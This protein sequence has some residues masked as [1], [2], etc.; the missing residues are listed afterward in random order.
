MSTLDELK[1]RAQ[2]TLA[3]F[4]TGQKIGIA[5]VAVLTFGALIWV[6]TS[7]SSPNYRTLYADLDESTAAKIVEELEAQQIPFELNGP[8]A[9]AV[10]QEQLYRAR[11]HLAGLGLPS[12]DGKGYELF[13]DAEFGMT[14]FTQKVNYQRALEHELARTISAMR[15][16]KSARVHLVLPER[17]LF[18][19]EQ[20][21][22]SASVALTLEP[23]QVPDNGQIQSMRYLVSS[24]I[25]SLEPGH[26]TIVDST[27]E[28]LA[29]PDRDG[30]VASAD[31]SLEAASKLEASL[32][33]RIVELLAPVVGRDNLRARVRAE[34]DTSTST[35]TDERYDPEKRAVRSEQ[36][37]ER[38]EAVDGEVVGGAPGIASNLPGREG[39]QTQQDE[40]LSKSQ[41]QETINYEVSRTVTQ[42]TRNGYSVDRLSVAVVLNEALL[43]APKDGEEPR[44]IDRER[45]A[46]LI[47]S[48]VGFQKE[49]G[50]QV[51]ITWER[52]IESPAPA[53]EPV[54]VYA[55]PE[56]YVPVAKYAFL[57]LL[58]LALLL[59]VVRP[60][61]K[62]VT[63]TEAAAFAETDEERES[64]G[65]SDDI[66][67]VG[68]TVAQVEE[69]LGVIDGE[70]EVTED[71]DRD[72]PY[73]Q[74]REEV[75]EL[76]SS[77]LDKTGDI[78]R[79]WIRMNDEDVVEVT[80]ES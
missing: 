29:R 42:T 43:A 79:Q 4:T 7:A 30:G 25:E 61:V 37:T 47:S 72:A 56:I 78:L 33:E 23:G 73:F 75:I 16:V 35:Q 60:I 3:Q 12:G 49:R 57:L 14:A 70:F 24:A 77:D 76:G 2:S 45:I 19:E 11:L 52:F 53:A 21:K 39:E 58:T 28:L 13:D 74:L 18:K 65:E 40:N 26:V 50:D 22:P 32:E 9:V 41:L 20:R 10:P 1:E 62:A 17:S 68:Q 54:P 38:K 71:D 55:R 69:K 46:S 66:E 27:G 5:A 63:A 8:G 59:F 36:R 34:L 44:E 6:V 48:A 64:D 67:L 15:P 51:E 80:H 31:E